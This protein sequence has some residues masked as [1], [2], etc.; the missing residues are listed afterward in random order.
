VIC[1]SRAGFV[2]LLKCPD[3]SSRVERDRLR[4]PTGLELLAA[5]KLSIGMCCWRVL[6][7][8]WL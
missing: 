7:V 4:L 8:G 2:P 1:S 6:T 5:G 3:L